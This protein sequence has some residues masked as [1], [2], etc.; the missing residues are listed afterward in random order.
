MDTNKIQEE[1]DLKKW[2][3]SLKQNRDTCGEYAYC[4][5]CQIDMENP[6]ANA[7]LKSEEMAK[8][9]AAKAKPA[10]PKAK[11]AAKK[12]TAVSAD[13]EVAASVLEEPAKKA[14]AKKTSAKTKTSK[15]E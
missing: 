15:S 5:Y 3:D 4:A 1:L 7:M 9:S 13:K 8:K 6:C 11:P 12:E 10:S 14:P 2:Y